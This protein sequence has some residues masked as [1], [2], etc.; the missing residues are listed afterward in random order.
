MRKEGG[1]DV[2]V[3]QQLLGE[4]LQEFG[5]KWIRDNHLDRRIP[6]VLYIVQ[7]ERKSFFLTCIE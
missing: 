4:V 6:N 2:E 5:R 1:S 3:F 7:R